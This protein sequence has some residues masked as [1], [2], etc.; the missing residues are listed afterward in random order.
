MWISLL[1]RVV[2]NRRWLDEY[3]NISAR[4]DCSSLRPTQFIPSMIR[5]RV[6]M[7]FC[8]S[9]LTVCA[10]T[11]FIIKLHTSS[12]FPRHSFCPSFIWLRSTYLARRLCT[13]VFLTIILIIRLLLSSSSILQNSLWTHTHINKWSQAWRCSFNLTWAECSLK[14]PWFPNGYI[15]NFIIG[16]YCIDQ[17]VTVK[18]SHCLHSWFFICISPTF[19]LKLGLLVSDFFEALISRGIDFHSSFDFLFLLQKQ[20]IWT[21]SLL[22]ILRWLK[23]LST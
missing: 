2:V 16:Y 5:T 20:S 12:V 1:L 11:V 6:A 9:A 4:C 10:I 3:E 23:W 14:T 7:V 15:F 18:L 17:P 21:L 13:L 8:L 19:P 22:M